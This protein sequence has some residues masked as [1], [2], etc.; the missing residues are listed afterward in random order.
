VY[1]DVGFPFGGIAGP[2]DFQRLLRWWSVTVLVLLDGM[3]E[4]VNQ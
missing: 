3:Y 4:F 2:A 1:D